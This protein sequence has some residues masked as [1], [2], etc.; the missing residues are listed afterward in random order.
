LAEEP[1]DSAEFQQ[2][3]RA[4]RTGLIREFWDFLKHNKKW[5]ILPILVVLLVIGLLAVLGATGLSP[6]LYALF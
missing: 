1:A 6:F 2:E 5:W 3:A 4:A